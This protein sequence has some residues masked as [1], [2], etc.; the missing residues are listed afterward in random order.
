MDSISVEKSCCGDALGV[1]AKA[2][3]KSVI[4]FNGIKVGEDI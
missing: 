1:G 4:Y 3:L 2:C